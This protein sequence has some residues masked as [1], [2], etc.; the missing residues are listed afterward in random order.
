MARGS[1]YG[2]KP[3]LREPAE[4]TIPKRR[5]TRDLSLERGEEEEPETEA[6]PA[7]APRA[8]ITTS[9]IPVYEMKEHPLARH[10][11][12][13][14]KVIISLSCAIIFILVLVSAG[15][16]QRSGDP[17]TIAFQGGQSFPIQV[18]GSLDNVT[19]WVNSSGP[20]PAKTPIPTHNGPY[21]VLGPPTITADFINQVLSSYGSPAA[22]KGLA[23]YNY[24]V[25]YGIDP[26][27][28]LAFFLHES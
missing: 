6:L 3:T 20:V 2:E 22:G 1:S 5:A 12:W 23:L 25:E 17:H 18:G 8:L 19:S 7:P 13:I 16:F 15:M 14:N 10:T 26:V 4:F 28:A 11:P 21:A 9:A 24:G 27:L